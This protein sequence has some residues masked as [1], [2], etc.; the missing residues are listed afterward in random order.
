MNFKFHKVLIIGGGPS[1]IGHEN[2][3]DAA[4]FQTILTFQKFNIETVLLDNNPFT[5][6]MDLLPDQDIFINE[7]NY[8]NVLKLIKKVHPD[9]ILPTLGGLH[10]I[11]LCKELIHQNILKNQGIKLLGA[12]QLA[13]FMI[14]N[15]IKMGRIIKNIHENIV[16][17]TI[18]SSRENAVY[19]ARKIGL[20][21]IIKP[22]SKHHSPY[23]QNC[24]NFNQLDHALD[25]FFKHSSSHQCIVEK[26][27]V[28]YKEL[29]TIGIRDE[30][31]TKILISGLENIDAVGIHSGDSI[32]ITPFQ[33]I[34]DPEYQ[35]IRNATFKIMDALRVIGFCHVQ[36]ALDP[37]TKRFFVT[38]ITPSFSRSITLAAKATNYPIAAVCSQLILGRTLEHVSLPSKYSH[39]IPIME[40]TLDHVVIKMPLWPFD[41][42]PKASHHLNTVMKSVGSTIGIGR[43]I[44][45]AMLKA[46]RSSQFSPR[47]VLP[48]M[49]NLSDDNMINQLIHPRQNRILVLIE[50]LRRGY[51]PAELAELTK[52][53][54][55]Y[56]YKLRNLLVVENEII[57]HPLRSSTVKAAHNSGFG[58][59]M[60]AETWNV[61]IEKIF[62][63]GQKCHS[64]P[65]YKAIESTAG[66]VLNTSSSYYSSYEKENESHRFKSDSALVIGRGGNQLGPNTAADYYTAQTL[67]QL[68][69]SGYQT[70]IMN[71]NPNSISLCPK[72][73]NK[74]YIEPI[75][76][77]NILDIIYLEQPKIIFIPGNRHYL[78]RELSKR[79]F[80]IAII[81]PDQETGV[82]RDSKASFGIDFFV[83]A[84]HCHPISTVQFNLKQPQQ[85]KLI[86]KYMAPLKMSSRVIKNLTS[87]AINEIKSSSEWHGLVQA[88]FIHNQNGNHLIGVRPLKIT[89]TV[90]LNRVTGIN[91]I[92]ELIKYYTHQLDRNKLIHL[93]EHQEQKHL[94]MVAKFPFRQLKVRTKNGLDS[95]IVGAKIEPKQ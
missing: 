30:S 39:L 43:T 24:K 80:K 13:I 74:Q 11:R 93:L 20:P 14:N 49:Q 50:A 19:I 12:S 15:P 60:L 54:Q 84:N 52:I 10:A 81:P 92:H 37:T 57:N 78:V 58:D 32:I 41:N 64:I 35:K 85:L 69:H 18:V 59:G 33:T 79:H 1:S 40:P 44:E 22:V 3:L 7:I 55:F 25:N 63:L 46:L 45:E 68:H 21:V 83:T 53:D 36:F 87:Q 94:E 61:P 34:T 9:A 4:T 66:E 75:Q 89:E 90:F 47:D 2:E 73:S 27:I 51:S 67:I 82:L 95:Q 88:L 86:F 17:S 31:G 65:T 42:V 76:L 71:N 70:I 38:K 23:R 91:W 48:S 8:S 6:T 72:I 5:L 77:G 26:S 56:F 62:D 29:E 16:P 28:G